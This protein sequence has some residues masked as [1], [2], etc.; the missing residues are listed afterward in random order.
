MPVYP[1]AVIMVFC[2]APIPGQVKTRLIPYLSASEAAQLH[3]ELAELTLATATQ[4]GLCDVE[5]W[6]SPYI[7]HPYFAQLA[8]HYPIKLKM[9]DGADLGERMLNAF[10]DALKKYKNV[11]L[12][13]CDCPSLTADDLAQALTALADNKACA[14]GPA[15]DGG[16]YLLGL[17]RLIPELFED[18]PWGTSDVLN[19]TR[20]KLR[21]MS[22]FG[23]E[24]ATRWD[25]DTVE[26]LMR[27]RKR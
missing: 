13:G 10:D 25:L 1:D 5:L 22:I 19:L 21:S 14:L 27:Y 16:Y 4:S 23:F 26:D 17:K 2:K 11:V 3:C 8:R 12:I 9:Q 18:I 6:C 20:A 15:E 7:E 24:T